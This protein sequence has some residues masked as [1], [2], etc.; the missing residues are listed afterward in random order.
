MHRTFATIAAL[1]WLS[2][3]STGP[4]LAALAPKY[5]RLRQLREVVG[6]PGLMEVLGDDPVERIEAVGP[7]V[8]RVTTGRCA[9]EAR[10]V[11]GDMPAGMTGPSPLSVRFGMR[12]CD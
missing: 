2:V 7:G 9:V 6:A 5:E 3:L 10:V 8:Y 11:P 4:A 12:L 1:S